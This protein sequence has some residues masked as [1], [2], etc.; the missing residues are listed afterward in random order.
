MMASAIHVAHQRRRPRLLRPRNISANRRG[1]GGGLSV[2][3]LRRGLF[4]GQRLVGL[5]CFSFFL[6]DADADAD[7]DVVEAAP[8][9]PGSAPPPRPLL[10]PPPPFT[11]ERLVGAELAAAPLPLGSQSAR[12]REREIEEKHRRERSEKEDRFLRRKREGKRK[13]EKKTRPLHLL[14]EGVAATT[15]HKNHTFP[16]RFPTLFF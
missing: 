9:L 14:A 11:V 10:L 3:C 4:P 1:A 2:L 6:L 16:V 12:A 13:K 7:D 15:T 8:A 5:G